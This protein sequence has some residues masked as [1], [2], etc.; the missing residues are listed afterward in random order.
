MKRLIALCAALCSLAMPL[1]SA[2]AQ[3]APSYPDRP[4]NWIVPFSAGSVYDNTA[5]IIGNVLGEKLGQPVVVQNKPGASGIIGTQ[6]VQQAKPD[7]YTMLYSGVS[8]LAIYTWL[9]KKLPYSPLT[10]FVPVNGVFDTTP[11]LVVNAAKPYKTIGEFVDHLKKNPGKVNYGA[12][13]GGLVHLTGEMLQAATG[14]S[15]QVVPY[16]ESAKLYADLMSG[17]VDGMFDF[18]ATIRP[19][20]EAGKV[21]PLAVASPQRLQALPNVPT[22]KESGI[23]VNITAWAAVV[24]PAGTPP[25]IVNKMSAA[26]AETMRDPSVVKY[27]ETN[28]FGN[29]GDIGPEKLRELIVGETAKF[30]VLVER[31]G[32]SVD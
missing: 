18:T 25:E 10:S 19:Y 26:F 11:I 3:Q 7:G 8:P 16:T 22:F 15:M 12:T 31:S 29:L 4:I 24:M 27:M 28:D 2:Q 6:L 23:D 32:V 20:I 14:T 5:R 1:T 9:Y 17:I 21:I 13:L 30:K